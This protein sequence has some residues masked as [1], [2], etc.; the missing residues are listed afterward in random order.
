MK[1]LVL[2]SATSGPLVRF[3]VNFRSRSEG[4][5]IFTLSAED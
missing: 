2:C 3:S 4:K 5:L 1:L